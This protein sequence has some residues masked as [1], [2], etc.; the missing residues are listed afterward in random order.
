MFLRRAVPGLLALLVL[1]FA[2]WW[3]FE[4][5][6]YI[7]I[8]QSEIQQ[9]L[10]DRFPIKR[11]VAQACIELL[12]PVAILSDGSDRIGF[13]SAVIASGGKQQFPGQVAFTG[14]V[15]YVRDDGKFY[16]DDIEIQ[17]LQIASVPPNLAAVVKAL[18][19]GIIRT[20]LQNYPI[21]TIKGSTGKE[22]LAWLAVGDV[23]VVNGKL[24]VTFKLA[25]S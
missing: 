15:R 5:L 7:D 4:K 17:T 6:A 11:C 23:Q 18:G 22:M 9:R 19:P 3:T 8:S 25:K 2:A 14:K 21:Y 10:S 12:S 20:G 24:R 13:S 16:L 1:C